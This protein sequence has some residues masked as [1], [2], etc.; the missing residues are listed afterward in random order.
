MLTEKE[1]NKVCSHCAA[2]LYK[3]YGRCRDIDYDEL[4]N[5]GCIRFIEAEPINI[6]KAYSD[7]YLYMLH[8]IQD[9]HINRQ[10]IQDNEEKRQNYYRHVDVDIDIVIDIHEAFKSLSVDDVNIIVDHVFKDRT[11]RELMSK[12]HKDHPGS[13][14]HMFDKAMSSL[15]MLVKSWF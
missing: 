9:N 3:K 12:Y 14:K 8:Y 13:I 4:Y 10:K 6:K 15:K 7:A 1:K 11:F 2:S 5:I